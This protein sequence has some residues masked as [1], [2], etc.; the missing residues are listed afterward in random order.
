MAAQ[1]LLLLALAVRL[2]SPGPVLFRQA[3]L[4]RDQRPFTILKVRTM[5]HLDAATIDQ[6]R[7]HVVAEGRNPRITRVG[8]ILRA[9]SLD[10]LSQVWN[11]EHGDMSLV[12]PRPAL[13]E[14]LHAIP[15]H[16]LGR[17]DVA[18]GVTGLAQVRGRRSL[19]WLEVLKAD[20]EYACSPTLPGDL[21]I[22]LRT[23]L[24]VL[25]REGIYGSEGE[26]WRAYLAR[27]E[28]D[29]AVGSL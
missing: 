1:I 5:L 19:Q 16:M 29:G 17:F 4:R 10:E 6:L 20:T 9:T 25:R 11:V 27:T 15:E 12:G 2:D 8:R 22:L 28:S 3:R 26:N 18:P 7:E 23:V 14:Q 13:P 24:A 21:A